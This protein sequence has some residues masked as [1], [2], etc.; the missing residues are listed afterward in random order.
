MLNQVV[1]ASRE[2]WREQVGPWLGRR[3][4][5]NVERLT[6]H[7]GGPAR[8]RVVVFLGLVLALN[9]ADNGAV[10]A[11]AA[12]LEP[13]L[14]IGPAKIGLLVTVSSLVGALA[15]L[16]FGIL[17]DK[18]WRVPLLSISVALWGVAEMA[19]GFSSSFGMLLLTRLC[20][21][22]RA[23]VLQLPAT[24]AVAK[25]PARSQVGERSRLA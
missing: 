21:G 11:I 6:E 7:L 16:F 1:T 24:A 25:E 10:G 8:R 4:Q 14:H 12:Q 22:Q 19:S 17:T 15:A 5:R 2:L 9:S 3:V 23:T 20:E 18:V 13:A